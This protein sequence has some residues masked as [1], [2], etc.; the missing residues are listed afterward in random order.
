MVNSNSTWS[1]GR[2]N[3]IAEGL[4]QRAAV[5]PQYLLAPGVEMMDIQVDLPAGQVH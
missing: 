5:M 3:R 1:K 4:D 2:A